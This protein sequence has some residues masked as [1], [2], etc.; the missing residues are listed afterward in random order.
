M[1][2]TV[3]FYFAGRFFGLVSFLFLFCTTVIND[4]S[5]FDYLGGVGKKGGKKCVG[6]RME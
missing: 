2:E 4:S 3:F 6:D 5:M 1:G